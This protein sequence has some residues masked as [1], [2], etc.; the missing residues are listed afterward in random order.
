MLQLEPKGKKYSQMG[1]E[2]AVVRNRR[3]GTGTL[4]NEKD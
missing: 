3:R 4:E 2:R 1:E